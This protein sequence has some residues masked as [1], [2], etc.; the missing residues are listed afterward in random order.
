MP[1][2]YKIR[3]GLNINLTGK[4]EKS[5]GKSNPADLYAVKP[6]DFHGLI[7]RL[8]VKEGAEVKAGSPLFVDKNIPEI[9]FTSPVS[10]IVAAINRGE[11]RMVLEVV[12][13]ASNVQQYEV[14]NTGDPLEMTRESVI[15]NLLKSGLW[16]VVRQRPY[17]I[18]ANPKHTPK[19][20][21]VSSFDTA[22]LAPELDYVI[23]GSEA[24]FQVGINALTRLTNGKVHVNIS[25]EYPEKNVFSTVQHAQVN[26]FSG[27][28]PAGNLSVQIQRIDPLNKGEVIWVVSPQDVVMLGRLFSKGIYDATKVVAVAGSEVKNPRYFRVISGSS[29]KSIV[30]GNVLDGPHRY[31]GGNPLT[32]T[33]VS[34]GGFIGFYDSLLSVIPEG[35]QYEFLGWALPGFNKYSFSRSYWSWL[36]PGRSYVL[37]TNM[38]GGHRAFVITGLYEKVFPLD[39]YPMQLLKSILA[40]DVDQ[41]EKLG[42]YEVAEE[43]FALC[44]FVCPS[45]TEMQTLVR[46]GLDLMIQEMS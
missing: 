2:V 33:Q 5:F 3:K 13:K 1:H 21:F 38:K 28:H 46:K 24:E 34:A 37:D 19:S 16:P 17:N 31:I 12:V 35:N 8:E 4:A 20:I 18:I 44:E 10:G 32:G 14:F 25:T 41:M 27:P 9:R 43:D 30:E 7:P 11:R 45:K 6:T 40:E 29:V 23:T 22:P 36:T 15:D 39:I 26:I 42:I